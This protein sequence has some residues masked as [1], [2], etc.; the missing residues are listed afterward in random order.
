MDKFEVGDQ[1][2]WT[3]V[4]GRRGTMSMT[5]V[6]GYIHEIDGDRARCRRGKKGKKD[7]WVSLEVLG[8]PGNRKGTK[9]IRDLFEAMTGKSLE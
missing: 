9:P 2:E 6:T 7:Y 4:G 3:H 5:A 1:V 8:R